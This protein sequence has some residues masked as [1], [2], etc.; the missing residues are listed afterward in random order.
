MNDFLKAITIALVAIVIGLVL[1]KKEKEFHLL[2]SVSTCC[3]ITYIGFSFLQPVIDFLQNLQVLGQLNLEMFQILLKCVGIGLIGE[4]A[5]L[6][7]V[8]TG[9]SAM[10]KMLQILSAI[11]IFWLSLPLFTKL[12]QLLESILGAL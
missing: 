8:D 11:F 3:F 12:F 9:N 6:L 1:S 5:C 7:C 2:L 10:G 4:I